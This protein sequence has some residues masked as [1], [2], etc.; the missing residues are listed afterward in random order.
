MRK[1]LVVLAI[2]G[3]SIAGSNFALAGGNC[4]ADGMSP[5]LS[6]QEGLTAPTDGMRASIARAAVRCNFH[7]LEELALDGSRGFTYTFGGDSG[8]PGGY[9]RNEERHGQPTLRRLVQLLDTS[10][11]EADDVYRNYDGPRTF[12]WPSAFKRNPTDG[13]WAQLKGIYPDRMIRQWKRDGQ[14]LGH[15]IFIKARNGDWQ[16]FVA[17]D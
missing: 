8:N 11:V 2:V 13:D 10:Y 1:T 7:R 12:V 6:D 14:Y 5:V 17:G 3:A 9:W 15:R 4:S 16:L